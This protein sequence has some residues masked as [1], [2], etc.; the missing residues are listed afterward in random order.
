MN[1]QSQKTRRGQGLIEFIICVAGIG[2]V[3]LLSLSMLGHKITDQWA[4][5]AGMLPCAHEEENKPIV[6]GRFA[7]WREN[8][9]V[10]EATGEVSWVDVTG[11]ADGDGELEN[12][13]VVGGASGSAFVAD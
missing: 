5:C 6:T 4:V 3:S 10:I 11:N 7:N 8:E 12:N 1:Y 13:I 9:G 2:L